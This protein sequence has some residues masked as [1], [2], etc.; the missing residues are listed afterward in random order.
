MKKPIAHVVGSAMIAVVVLAVTGCSGAAEARDPAQDG[1]GQF[2]FATGKNITCLDP[3]VGGDMPQ[4]SLAANYLDS[5]VSMDK[6]G[7][8]H[9]WL[10]TSWEVSDDGLRYT[11]HLRDDVTFTDGTPF[12][13]AAVKANLEHMVDPD[14]H[15]GTAGGYL[16]PYVKTTVVDETTAVVTLDRPYAAFLEVLAQ[17]FLGIQSPKALKRSQAENCASPVGTGPFKVVDYVP[18]SKVKLVRN[19]DYNSAPPFAEH[20]GP[21]HIAEL[22]WRIIPEDA[23]RYGMLRAGQVDAIDRMPAVN[24]AEARADDRV[25]LILQ[26]RPGNPTNLTFNITRPPFDDI[27]VRKAFLYGSYVKAG[28]ESV[29]FGTVTHAGGPLSSATRFYS[30]RFE[31]VYAPDQEKANRLLDEAGW[32]GRDDEGYRTKDGK[33]L[34][35]VLPYDPGSWP[36]AFTALMTQLQASAKQIGIEMVIQNLDTATVTK[37]TNTFQYDLRA[38]YWNT[39]TADVLRII[40]GSEYLPSNGFG[41]NRAGLSDPEL[42]RILNDALATNDPDERRRLYLEAQQIVSDGAYQLTLFNQASQIGVRTDRVSGV[43][44]EPSLSVPYLY[45]AKVVAAS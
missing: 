2:V 35:V 28:I 4:A 20:E 30:P 27:R 21:A 15:S 14:T 22:V 7:E 31:D 42:D 33:R 23:T 44:L 6:D 16:E 36:S 32:T 38:G 17:P 45:D 43:R 18:Q 5:I 3:H 9:P 40:L 13:A 11:F 37:R 12:N 25:S 34:S 41:S 24:F 29:Y 10:A 26:D 39:N 8:I 1:G 19:E